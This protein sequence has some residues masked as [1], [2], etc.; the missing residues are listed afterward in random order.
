MRAAFGFDLQQIDEARD[1]GLDAVQPGE[2]IE[3][4]QG[5]REPLGGR[6]LRPRRFL[7]TQRSGKTSQPPDRHAEACDEDRDGEDGNEFQ[8]GQQ[9]SEG[10]RCE[11]QGDPGVYGTRVRTCTHT[12]THHAD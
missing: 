4:R 6:V 8:A 7:S 5:P 11:D 3:L 9:E 12:G 2:A 1:L 10:D